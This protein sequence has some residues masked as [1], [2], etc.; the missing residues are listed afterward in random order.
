M[1]AEDA[2][3]ASAVRDVRSDGVQP[4]AGGMW[5]CGS[6]PDV[7]QPVS[8]APMSDDL[9]ELLAWMPRAYAARARRRAARRG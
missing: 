1:A 6:A 7:D 3:P 8:G 4:A 9:D 2:E 5:P